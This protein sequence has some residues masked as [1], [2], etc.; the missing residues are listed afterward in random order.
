MIKETTAKMTTIMTNTHL[1]PRKVP[2]R[3]LGALCAALVALAIVAAPTYAAFGFE[4]F[5]GTYQDPGGNPYTQAGGHPDKVTTDF[6]FNTTP[7]PPDSAFPFNLFPIPDGQVKDVH[8]GLPGGLVG[9]PTATPKCSIND[10]SAKPATQLCPP[11]SQVGQAYLH[12]TFT[13]LGP[14][15][16]FNMAPKNGSVAE[17]GINAIVVVRLAATVGSDN[18]VSISSVETSEGLPLAGLTTEFWGVPADH[19]AELGVTEL[20]RKPLLRMPTSCTGP[21]QTTITANQ[22]EDPANFQTASFLSHDNEVPPNPLGD[23]GCEN[24][25]FTPSVSLQTTSHQADSPT[26][27]DVSIK[28]PSE[29]FK[30][31]DGV[32]QADIRKV[33]LA[34][35][36]GLSLNP[37]AAGG[38]GSCTPQEIGLTS[39]VGTAPVRF[40]KAP[41]ACP[42]SSKIGTVQV[43][44]PA[45]EEGLGGSVYLAKQQDNPFDSLL[46]MYAV[47]EAPDRGVRIKLAGQIEAGEG[48]Q[49]T[50]TFD[51]NP[52]LPV[53][54]FDLKLNGGPRA[55]LRTPDQCGEYSA[56]MELTPWSAPES[57]PP[58]TRTSSI[59]VTSGPGGSPCPSSPAGFDPKLSGGSQN[60]VAGAYSPFGLRLTREDGTQQIGS[61]DV[62]PPQ[63]VLAKLAGIPYCPDAALASVSS[64][65][66]AGAAQLASPSCPAASQVG[67]VTVGDGAGS[68]P[69]YVDTGKIY[70][71]GPYKGAP[72]SLAVIAPAVAGPFDLGS[73]MVRNAVRV[74][75]E[76][77]Q[78]TTV[79]DPIPS[80]LHGIPLDLRDI[81]VN[82]NRDQFTLNPTSCEP[83]Q[84]GSKVT[85]LG[86][87]VATPSE[88]FQVGDCERLG[89]KPQL[90]IALA[91][92]THRAAHPRLRATLRAR[93]GDADIG[94]VSVL[95]PKSELLENAHIRTVC[96]RVQFTAGAGGGAGC[97]AGS[98]YGYAK[99]W[100]P[101]L[102][103]PLQGP[104]Y[105]RSNGGERELPDLVASLG[106]QIHLDLV[107]Y[108]DAVKARLRTR[109]LNTP[110]APVEKFVLTMQGGKKGLL[111]NN[112]DICRERQ[113]ASVQMDGQNG[114]VRDF[115]SPLQVKCGQSGKSARLG[116]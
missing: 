18:T 83:M 12:L 89:F 10:L 66:G 50:T 99:A 84:I 37:S 106:G 56:A 69:L 112:T 3:V 59:A 90:A 70:L 100:S 34:L 9:D 57:G 49:L 78:I 82:L 16:I 44:S 72:L 63:G 68:N 109:F 86:G 23:T 71:A 80:I 26:G 5:D 47:V 11:A 65:A 8:V 76:T 1:S 24:V 33:K 40:D 110:D 102:D 95:L 43:K 32:S 116:R 31:P 20:E 45:L 91:G 61:L 93:K 54:E 38:L 28:V 14:L 113:S 46:A 87:A 96:T 60:P 88:R 4:S 7:A 2:L 98:I 105:L 108:I 67:T 92:P 52:Q 35:P 85:S 6:R 51:E 29:G 101:L 19:L 36:Q 15:P 74:N 94:G 79:S 39:A 22:W 75:P 64:A 17:F 114:K 77:A 58:V 111:A 41:V 55:S 81:R 62:S 27:L 21:L 115:R 103:Q 48:G 107:G 53:E 73:V 97:P 25:Q 30:N 13:T 42:E 104:V